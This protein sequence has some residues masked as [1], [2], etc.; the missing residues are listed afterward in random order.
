M[1]T[2]NFNMEDPAKQ[3]QIR[4]GSHTYIPTAGKHGSYVPQP[5]KHQEYPKMMGTWPRPQ[6][7]DYKGDGKPDPQLRYELAI[8]AWDD[9]MTASVVNNKAEE[10]QWSK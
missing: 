5:Y 6:F 4:R 10:L 2:S 3:E 9:A 8:K 7:A 1:A